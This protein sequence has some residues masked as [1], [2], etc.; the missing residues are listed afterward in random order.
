MRRK[1]FL[2]ASA[3]AAAGLVCLLALRPRGNPMAPEDAS[4]ESPEVQEAL[5]VV[6]ELAADPEKAEQF[7]SDRANR[8]AR[9]SIVGAADRLSELAPPGL[10]GAQWTGEYLRLTVLAPMGE[11]RKLRLH[12]FLREEGG[13][14]RITGVQR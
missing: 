2:I 6:R 14:M 1:P 13:R 4:A 5:A 3:V 7:M 12:F 10:E 11:G 9:S 8:R